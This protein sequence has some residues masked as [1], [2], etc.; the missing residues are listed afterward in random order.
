MQEATQNLDEF[1]TTVS[2]TPSDYQINRKRIHAILK[3]IPG[4]LKNLSEAC[5][6]FQPIK[7]SIYLDRK[8]KVPSED[9][10][11]ICDCIKSTKATPEQLSDSRISIDCG[12]KCINRLMCTECEAVTC[13][14]EEICQNR[15]FQQ[16]LDKC[17]YPFKA[18]SKGWGLKSGEF[19]SKGSFVLQYM[20]EIFSVKSSEG[21]KRMAQC[22]Q[23]TCTYLMKLSSKELIDPTFKGS[24]AR[25]INH[26]CEP[27]CITQK[28]NV[29]GEV[30]VGIFSIKDIPI[31][32]ELTF[33]YKFDVYKTPL[34]ICY[35]GTHSCRGYLGLRPL[36]YTNEE[37]ENKMNNLPCEIC[38]GNYENDDDRLLI[39]D[40]CNNGFHLECLTPS[41][42]SVPKGAWFCAECLSNSPQETTVEDSQEPKTHLAQV[43]TGMQIESNLVTDDIRS[44]KKQQFF[45]L[46]TKVFKEFD[47]VCVSKGFYTLLN[48]PKI[49]EKINENSEIVLKKYVLTM[50]ELSIFKEKGAKLISS[51]PNIRFFWG[52]NEQYYRQYFL[53]QIEVSINCSS[54]QSEYID[55]LFNLIEESTINFK[56]SIGS[57]E[58]SFKIPAIFLKRVLGEYYTNLKSVEREFNVKVHFNKKHVTDDCF[59]IHYLTTII[60]KSRSDNIARAH[61]FIKSKMSE[62]VARR[63]YMSRSDIKIII[64]KLS[65][66]KK[67][68]GPTEIRCC[69][70][71]AL[72]DIN[73]PFYTIYYK[74]KEVAFIGTMEEVLRAERKVMEIIEASRKFEE[75]SMSLNFL[76]PVCDKSILINIKNKSEKNFPG[77]KIILYDP[78]YPRKNISVT[79]TSSYR[80]FDE[81]LDYFKHQLDKKEI[82]GFNFENYQL[83]MLFQMSKHF[84][85]YIHNF[86]QTKSMNFMKSWD[87]ITAEFDF[88]YRGFNSSM[89]MLENRI[90]LD[91]EFLF[92]IL[93]VNMLYKRENLSRINMTIPQIIEIV[94]SALSRKTDLPANEYSIF[95]PNKQSKIDVG[96]DL[97]RNLST[98][99][100]HKAD[101]NSIVMEYD[102][103]GSY[104]YRQGGYVPTHGQ[105]QNAFQ[106]SGSPIY[107]F[108]N[109]NKFSEERN[110]EER[111][112]HR[113]RN[114]QRESPVRKFAPVD[115]S[116]WFK[117]NQ[118]ESSQIS[119][120]K[121]NQID[122]TKRDNRPQIRNQ[123]PSENHSSNSSRNFNQPRHKHEY[124][125]IKP[126]FNDERRHYREENKEYQIRDS[127]KYSRERDEPRE[128]HRVEYRS[129][130]Q[131]NPTADY[132][133]QPNRLDREKEFQ[134]DRHQRERS[135]YS[136]N[137]G[138]PMNLNPD[139]QRYPKNDYELSSVSSV[140]IKQS[141]Y[142]KRRETRHH[143]YPQPR[144]NP[145]ESQTRPYPRDNYSKIQYSQSNYYE[146][147]RPE[148]P[149]LRRRESFDESKF[150]FNKRRKY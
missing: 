54:S 12:Q 113:R 40:K 57:A 100:L 121:S 142:Q 96:L 89:K 67:K 26:S 25:F 11:Y 63:K 101:G 28:W 150:D 22:A 126:S 85:K 65:H 103:P 21:I 56:E 33:D 94:K 145:P 105:H 133:T 125:Y 15:K 60:L 48:D 131:R 87:N 110:L 50:L 115:R 32:E 52:K 72:R 141:N 7:K 29:L 136:Q 8:Q 31:G 84:F 30:V 106:D 71:N 47:E 128:Y 118:S 13:P 149:D 117:D 44:R 124:D 27:N 83:Q 97:A 61:A 37:W 122:K 64:S 36:N 66:I 14:C 148:D 23:S 74:D 93:R 80:E 39:C 90:F 95:N 77:N 17:V 41:L 79:L 144:F 6:V 139:I 43:D 116:G 34:S 18:G 16:Q 99:T 140:D 73:H 129:D 78:L 70:D 109:R 146:Y 130:K 138:M 119:F 45:D 143:D 24:I 114:Y 134:K 112:S 91:Q 76:I 10:I 75:T 35:C 88:N 123:D 104:R 55:I 42:N 3:S 9:D 132:H 86:K 82:Y 58:K 147:R 4:G 19:I 127:V 107:Y 120:E 68:I 20:G 92:Y 108:E 111:E 59:P 81:Y 49:I 102:Y 5:K 53:K 2:Q 62:L 69:R 46:K 135:K 1:E 38:K 137:Y 98:N 51:F